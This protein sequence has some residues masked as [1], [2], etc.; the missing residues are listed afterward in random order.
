MGRLN[1]LQTDKEAEVAVVVLDEYQRRGLATDLLCPLI[2]IARD[3]KLRRIVA[4]MLRD[5]L[6][7]QTICRKLDFR[8]HLL[9]D[10]CAVQAVLDTIKGPFSY[11]PLG[12]NGHARAARLNVILVT[13]LG[14]PDC[15]HLT[16]LRA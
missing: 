1:K 13:L 2:H 5:N 7:T 15:R 8:M 11:L 3:E 4:E 10:P 9:S 14:D 6:A 12:L 16:P